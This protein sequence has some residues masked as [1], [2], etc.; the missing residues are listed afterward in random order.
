MACPM[1]ACH[2]EYWWSVFCM[3]CCVS[4]MVV[5]LLSWRWCSIYL[6]MVASAKQRHTSPLVVTWY[7]F[8]VLLLVVVEVSEVPLLTRTLLPR[9]LRV[10]RG[11]LMPTSM[12]S[13]VPTGRSRLVLAHIASVCQ[14]FRNWVSATI[15]RLRFTS[16]PHRSTSARCRLPNLQIKGERIHNI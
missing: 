1:S 14:S 15:S 2:W 12:L 11:W 16:Q 5:S 3:A 6:V 13:L 4:S 7:F 8:I 10:I 9:A